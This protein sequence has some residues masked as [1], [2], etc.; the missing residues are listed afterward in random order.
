M[1]AETLLR[2]E[3]IGVY[4]GTHGLM[5]NKK[6]KWIFRN[7]NFQIYQGESLGVIGRNGIGKSTLL[8]TL[9][10]IISPNEG[11][12]K[13]AQNKKAALLSLRTGFVPQLSGRTNIFISAM[14]QGMNYND[15]KLILNDVIEFSE[16]GKDIDLPL[17]N[18]SDGMKARLGFSI[19]MQVKP[20]IFLIDEVLGVG[21]AV[22]RKKSAEAMKELVLSDQTVVLVSHNPDTIKDLCT[23]AIWIENGSIMAEGQPENVLLQYNNHF[24][25]TA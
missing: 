18:Y 2:A 25:I 8:K 19:G 5:R 9:A 14:M 1:T 24:S 21:D 16:I 12:V 3:R 6:G 23:R 17:E 20:D 10:G 7:L 11:Y 13:L 22:F 15:V 4:F